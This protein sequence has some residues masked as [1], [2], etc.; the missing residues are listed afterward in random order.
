MDRPC[1]KPIIQRPDRP[2]LLVNDFTSDDPEARFYVPVL[3]FIVG[4]VY[5]TAIL[6]L[7][8]GFREWSA[9]RAASG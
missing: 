5:A 7:L 1:S 9:A 3:N 6:Y 2:G 4:T 8:E